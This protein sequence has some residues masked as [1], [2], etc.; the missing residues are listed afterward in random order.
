MPRFESSGYA[1]LPDALYVEVPGL[2]QVPAHRLAEQCVTIARRDA[3][4]LSG[5]LANGLRPFSGD[6]FFGIRWDTSIVWFL[7]AGTRPRTMRSLAGRVIPMWL[8]DPRGALKKQNPKAKTR[9]TRSGR[10][11][12]LIFRR[13]A[14]Q[15]QRRPD[16][17]L[18][19]FPGAPGRIASRESAR[20]LTT[21]GKVGGRIALNNSGVRWRHPGLQSRGFIRNAVMT[22]SK[23]SGFQGNIAVRDLGRAG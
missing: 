13:A 12:V 16:G 10:P 15:G 21:P 5:A 22:V 4:K 17:K 19:S 14:K 18:A 7:E 1:G 8:D 9:I 2:Q 11:Q 3:P 6:G 23:S 20:P